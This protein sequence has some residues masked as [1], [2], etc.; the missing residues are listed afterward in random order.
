MTEKDLYQHLWDKPEHAI[1]ARLGSRY[2]QRS[3]FCATQEEYSHQ[4][5]PVEELSHTLVACPVIFHFAVDVGWRQTYLHMS[6]IQECHRATCLAHLRTRL[7]KR[8]RKLLNRPASFWYGILT[9][10]R[11]LQL[12]LVS[13]WRMK[14]QPPSLRSHICSQDLPELCMFAAK[15]A[16]NVSVWGVCTLKGMYTAWNVISDFSLRD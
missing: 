3:C 2:L 5:L 7:N 12:D 13:V 1:W 4:Q 6:L 16:E 15:H 10:D 9:V 8:G 14:N 11:R